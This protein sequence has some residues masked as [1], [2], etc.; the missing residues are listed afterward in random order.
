MVEKRIEEV[1]NEVKEIDLTKLP[2]TK[3]NK[4]FMT[5]LPG[6][7]ISIAEIAQKSLK[8]GSKNGLCTG[9]IY[10]CQ[11]KSFGEGFVNGMLSGTAPEVGEYLA[12]YRYKKKNIDN[13]TKKFEFYKRCGIFFGNVIGSAVGSFTENFVF[14]KEKLTGEKIERTA[15]SV[16]LGIISGISDV[17]WDVVIQ[18]A[19]ELGSAA[20]EFME[21]EP[22]FGEKLK[23]FFGYLTNTML[24]L[25]EG[26]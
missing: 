3:E 1:Y 5:K 6:S 12:I 26:E 16:A 20:R 9:I 4:T 14:N 17:W 10:V 25:M 22:E 13:K 23:A 19:N 7:K 2:E 8:E 15:Y 21:Y 11:G 24:T 18:E